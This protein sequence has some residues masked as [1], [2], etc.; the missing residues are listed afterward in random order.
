MRKIRDMKYRFRRLLLLA[1]FVGCLSNAMFAQDSVQMN[2]S[3]QI[4][5]LQSGEALGDINISVLQVSGLNTV[6]D[7]TGH[8]QINIPDENATLMLSYPGYKSQNFPL[9]GR[10]DILV[11][12]LEANLKSISD[13]IPVAYG[14]KAIEDLTEAVSLVNEEMLRNQSAESLESMMQGVTTGV[15]VTQRSGFPGSGAEVY[16]RGANS[17]NTSH[18]PLYIIDGFLLKTDLFEN[19]LSQGTPYNPLVDINP[20]DIESITVLK[21][22]FSASTYGA[23]AA[24]GVILINT[25]QGSQGASTLD[26]SSQFG[27]VMA[28]DN[29]SLLDATQYKELVSELGYPEDFTPTQINSTFG[30]LLDTN[31]GDRFDNNTNWQDEIFQSAFTHNHHLRLKGGDGISKYMFTMG[32]TGKD[33]VID[34]THLSRLTSRFNLDYQ[35]TSKLTFFSRIS[36]TNTNIT[37][38]D[39][40]LSLYNPIIVATTKAPILEPYDMSY[41][42]HPL[43]SADVLGKSNP[44][45]IIEGLNNYS[46]VNRFIGTVGVGYDFSTALK[47]KTTFG[48]DYF[49]LREDRFIPS[50]GITRYQN[51]IN[52]TSL[53]VSKEHMFTNETVL[54]YNKLLDYVH[55]VSFAVGFALQSNQFQTDYGSAINTPSDKFTSLGSGAKMDSINYEGGKWNTLSYFGNAHYIYND[56][57]YLSA[58]LRVDGSSRFGE[59]NRM[60]YF[61]GLALAWKLSSEPFFQNISSINMLK[62][63]AS[64]G[65]SGS[66]DISN[67]SSLAYYIPANYQLMGGYR[68][69]NLRNPDLKWET[70]AQMDVGVD[71]SVFSQRLNIYAD[72]Y[73]KITSDL[74][75]YEKIPWESGFDY[76]V[77]NMGEIENRGFEI[78]I[79][80]KILTGN[81]KWDLGVNFSKNNNTILDL[82]NGDVVRRYGIFE[83]IAREGESLGSIYGYK[84]IGIYQSESEIQELNTG[85]DPRGYGYE[86]FQPG[87]L[88]FEDINTDGEINEKD[89]T[90][91]GCTSPD[92]YGGI[93]SKLTYKGFSLFAL[94][95]YAAGYEVV[96][97]LRSIL[98]SMK[99][100]NNQTTRTLD[101]WTAQGDQTD[102]PRASLGDPS[103]NSRMSSRWVEDGSYIRLKTLTLSY[104]LS[105]ATVD[106]TFLRSLT[107]YV[108]GHN[109]LTWGTFQGYD[110]EFSTNTDVMNA[111]L[112]YAGIP[113]TRMYMAGIRFG[114]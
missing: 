41:L 55:H 110:P 31:P 95:N 14:Q 47:L 99:N 71:L 46:V 103:G 97:G 9:R 59:N 58:N 63:R 50:E 40:G 64:Y 56:K 62:L 108:S 11:Q 43:D 111:G 53:Q 33:G 10:T 7:S 83:G 27:Y 57:Y 67:Y 89:K 20:E 12:M 25:Y 16:I 5:S 72:Y 74:L 4:V 85:V 61:P 13:P 44:L 8:F 101:R 3:G 19:T 35:I 60:G 17:I 104:T 98:E 88:I 22:G 81:L 28:P 15:H 86:P 112:Y 77:V 32:Y 90:I 106:K 80:G 66:D 82:P 76:R 34:N 2:I 96:D 6:T 75:T 49:R 38:H 21:D 93:N 65:I 52:Q 23:R 100:Y 107:V 105:K 94:V 73:I 68:P 29:L 91:L 48:M 42:S 92:Y 30:K 39:Q 109:L 54:E 37:A 70:T 1:I 51:R 84:V 36:Y 78:G 69:G 102:V 26:L 114:L 79:S 18:H 87:D 45:A 24:N 113:Q